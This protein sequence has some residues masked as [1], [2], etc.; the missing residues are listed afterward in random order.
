MIFFCTCDVPADAAR[1]LQVLAH[2]LQGQILDSRWAGESGR[3]L[4][5]SG[6]KKETRR[7]NVR[8]RMG[9]MWIQEREK[10]RLEKGG[11]E[12]KGNDVQR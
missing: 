6:E 9:E 7:R 3:Y 11:S 4:L 1:R 10:G 2:L 12:R 5:K 8:N